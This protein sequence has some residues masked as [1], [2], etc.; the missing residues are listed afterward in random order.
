M[1]KHVLI[2]ADEYPQSNM[3]ATFVTILQKHEYMDYYRSPD[4]VISESLNRE[5]RYSYGAMLNFELVAPR[6]T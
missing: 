5:R 6:A 3:A 4:S 2:L 1:K